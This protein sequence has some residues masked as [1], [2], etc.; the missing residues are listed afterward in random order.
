MQIGAERTRA[1]HVTDKTEFFYGENGGNS[2]KFART[3]IDT[4]VD[5]VSG[6]G[7]HVPRV[8]ELYKGKVIAYSLGNFL[9]YRTLATNTQT[10]YSMISDDKIN[11]EGNLVSGNIIPIHLYLSVRYSTS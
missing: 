3:M 5:L 10:V 8:M 1:L 2:L 7:H 11:S 9:G 6:H 4:A